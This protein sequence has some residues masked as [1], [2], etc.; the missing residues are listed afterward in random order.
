MKRSATHILLNQMSWPYPG[1]RARDA[2]W[3]LRYGTPTLNDLLIAA[4]VM[5]AYNALIH[6]TQKERND[7]AA[8]LKTA[9]KEAYDAIHH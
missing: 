7:I 3:T 5:D 2:S 4:W 9:T 8:K 6:K 1:P